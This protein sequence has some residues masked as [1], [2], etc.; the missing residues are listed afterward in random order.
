MTQLDAI[1]AQHGDDGCPTSR[2]F[3]RELLIELRKTLL[4]R[5]GVALRV[6]PNRLGRRT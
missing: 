1:I 3:R 4:V 2:T 5:R 6:R